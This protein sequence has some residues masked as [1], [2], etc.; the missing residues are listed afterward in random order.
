MA[1]IP[2]K[3]GVVGYGGAFNMGRQ[4]LNEMRN[5][6]MIPTAVADLDA[7]R[8]VVAQKE[9][10]GIQT[11]LS[12]EEMLEK[13]DIDLVTIITPHN[14]HFE[15]ARQCLQ[16]GRH[17]ICEKPMTI[18]M[19]EADILIEEAKKRNLLVSIYHNRH[20]DG[21][22][23]RA[24]EAMRA[25]VERGRAAGLAVEKAEFA[26]LGLTPVSAALRGLFFAQAAAKR[27]PFAGD[28]PAPAPPPLTSIGVLG[29]GLM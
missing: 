24:V 9:F 15:L 16:A 26:R 29:A 13:S 20:W 25:G 2:P 17:A 22:V 3:V 14:T 11:Y 19:K 18:T 5:S 21:C 10:P 4:H 12:L 6:G 1:N 28:L 8:L 27:N 23:I 7:E